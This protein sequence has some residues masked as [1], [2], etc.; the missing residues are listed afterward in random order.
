MSVCSIRVFQWSSVYKCM[1]FSYP[2]YSLIQTLL[3][4]CEKKGVQITEGLLYV[5]FH[6]AG[7]ML[8]K[9]FTSVALSLLET[10]I[11][12]SV[13]EFIYIHRSTCQLL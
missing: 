10:V 8:W 3:K 2:D 13:I 6:S 4:L 5:I 7:H 1:G 12:L 11:V 9:P